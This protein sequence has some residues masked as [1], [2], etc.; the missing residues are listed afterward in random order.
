[1]RRIL[2]QPDTYSTP[3][4]SVAAMAIAGGRTRTLSGQLHM[5]AF[6]RLT[7]LY[8]DGPGGGIFGFRQHAV[9][10]A[11]GRSFRG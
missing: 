2:S 5:A 7:D 10:T 9:E 1:M 6:R 8:R 3:W 11:L 4:V